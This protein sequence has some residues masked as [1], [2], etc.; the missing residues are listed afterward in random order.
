MMSVAAVEKELLELERAYWEPAPVP[1]LKIG[2]TG[3][4][5]FQVVFAMS[6]LVELPCPRYHGRMFNPELSQFGYPPSS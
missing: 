5:E 4:K 2:S 3:P 1:C 6:H